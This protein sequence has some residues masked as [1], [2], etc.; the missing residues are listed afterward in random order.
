M[1]QKTL[2]ILLGLNL[3]GQ[4]LASL[5]TWDSKILVDTSMLDTKSKFALGAIRAGNNLMKVIYPAT[6]KREIKV[7][8][9]LDET[10]KAIE[11]FI[12]ELGLAKKEHSEI[13]DLALR[14]GK[15][16]VKRITGK[17]TKT[18]EEQEAEEY[19]RQAEKMLTGEEVEEESTE[20][21]AQ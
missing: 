3:L 7:Q 21:D 10:F 9:E 2:G 19:A 18:K 15:R 11:Q 5:N 16:H 12:Q 20:E 13:T 17:K 8:K 4:E 14:L 1:S 6:D